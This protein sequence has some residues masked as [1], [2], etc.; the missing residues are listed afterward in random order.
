MT[1]SLIFNKIFNLF[2]ASKRRDPP[3]FLELLFGPR[4]I[5]ASDPWCRPL[6]C[7]RRAWQRGLW[8]CVDCYVKQIRVYTVGGNLTKRTERCPSAL[9]EGVSGCGGITQVILI[10]DTAFEWPVSHSSL[11]TC[12]THLIGRRLRVPLSRS[13][14]VGEELSLLPCWESC[15]ARGLVTNRLHYPTR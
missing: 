8:G 6:S 2:V 9:H 12:G 1:Y 11:F 5:S 10:S 13:G 14:H 4:A 3:S 15:P 7:V